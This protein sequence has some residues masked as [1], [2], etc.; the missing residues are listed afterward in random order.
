[1]SKIFKRD[2][3]K[4][5]D[6][7][8]VFIKHSSNKN[9]SITSSITQSTADPYEIKKAEDIL[10]KLKEEAEN[11]KIDAQKTAE[12]IISNATKKEEIL[13]EQYKKNGYDE[14]YEAGYNEGKLSG[15]TEINK[16]KE[17]IQ[18]DG[19]E[20]QN[21]K[22]NIFKNTEIEIV[23]LIV[24][25]VDN[26]LY[27]EIQLNPELIIFLIRRGIEN[28]TIQNKAT[29]KICSEDY[30]VV[31]QNIEEIKKMVDGSKEIEVLKDFGL[32]KNDCIIETEFGNINC[33]LDL[34]IKSLKESMFFILNN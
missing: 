12:N 28:S 19:L 5:D 21:K 20:I 10:D 2:D 1:M 18:K 11:L 7:R 4:V 27:K 33:G 34:Q 6:N 26:I 30:D 13:Y 32:S 15:E 23:D 24:D 9:N 16:I 14:G 17:Q 25:I 22:N 29:I 8:K 3:I 31:A